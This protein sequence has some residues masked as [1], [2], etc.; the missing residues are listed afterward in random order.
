VAALR[1]VL[2]ADARVSVEPV[3]RI[4]RRAN[5]KYQAIIVEDGPTAGASPGGATTG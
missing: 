5:Q 2:G 3:E 4:P 1:T